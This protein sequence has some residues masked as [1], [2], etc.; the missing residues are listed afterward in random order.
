MNLRTSVHAATPAVHH[1]ASSNIN[2]NT[3]TNKE[4]L[5]C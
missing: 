3:N 2:T 5:A 1:L 4:R